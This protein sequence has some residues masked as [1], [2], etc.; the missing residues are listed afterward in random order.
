MTIRMPEYGTALSGQTRVLEELLRDAVPELLNFY[1]KAEQE[2]TIHKAGEHVENLPGGTSLVNPVSA[3][4]KALRSV[5]GSGL[6]IKDLGSGSEGLQ[7][8]LRTILKYSVNPSAPGFLDKLYAAPLPPGIVAELLLG[9]LNTNL[10]VY[11]VS[12]VLTIIEK[13]VT[14]RLACMFGL[15]GPRSGGISV[16]G[17]SASNMTSIVI[18]RNTLFPETKTQGNSA[19]NGRLLLFTSAHGH[20]SIEKA[21]QA[22]GLGSSSVISV[23]VDESGRMIPTELKR[24]IMVGKNHGHVPF[25]INATAGTTVLGSFDPFEEISKVAREHQMWLHVD[26]A[27]GGGFVFSQKLENKKKLQGIGLADSIA[28]NPH[29]MLGVPV[30][31]SF[32]LGKDL[33]EFQDANTLKAGY[34]FHDDLDDGVARGEDIVGSETNRFGHADDTEV[35][36]EPYDLADLTLQCGRR[37]DSLKF[38]FSWK[39]YGNMG[40]SNMVDNAHDLACHMSKL[41][42]KQSNLTPVLPVGQD[43]SCLQVCFYHTPQRKFVYG[44]LNESG[45]FHGMSERPAVTNAHV[46]EPSLKAELGRLN[47]KV[48]AGIAKKLI[49][50]GFMVDFA[51]ALEGQEDKGSFFRVVVNIST[52]RETVERLIEE[53][54]IE[55]DVLV[56]NLEKQ[57]RTS[58]DII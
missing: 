54:V 10:H 13:N 44:L 11:Q 19:V 4:H 5:L 16:Q 12:P 9:V 32:L 14:K 8:V 23:P 3:T 30:T 15:D 41:V 47:S 40:Y 53:I 34:L 42:E 27:W 1:Q 7:D 52:I 37:G 33:K 21:A 22:L 18:A 35:W 49:P 6:D 24:L 48:T 39:Y 20:Y 50:R 29:K 36:E 43:P 25:Y 17:G 58:T 28:T 56:A 38:F 57:Q 26:A 31:C 2:K 51:P 46:D 55:G 45:Y